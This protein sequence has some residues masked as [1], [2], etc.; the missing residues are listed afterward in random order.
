MK[1]R[2][3]IKAAAFS[4]PMLFCGR[5]FGAGNS[6]PNS[7]CNVGVIGCG[8]QAAGHLNAI[9][10]MPDAV[11]SAVCDVDDSR[12]KYWA[13]RG[14]KKYY[15]R[16]LSGMRP[17][18]FKDFRELLLDPSIDAVYVTTPDHWHALICI[19]AARAGKAV[20]CEKPMTFTIEE[21]R[22]VTDAVQRAGIAFQVGSQQRSQESF[23]HAAQL[24]RNG[25][26]G[27][28]KNVWV[29]LNYGVASSRN[30]KY[31]AVPA[32]IDWDMWCGPAPYNPYSQR[33]L[34]L[35]NPGAENPYS[36]MIC[37]EWRDHL[38]YGNS[39]QADFGAHHYD[40]AMWGLGLDGMG[41][42]RVVVSDAGDIPG[43]KNWRQ[44]FYELS[45]GVKIYKGHPG[46]G[47]C[48]EDYPVIF[49]G[50]EGVAAADRGGMEKF[51]GSKPYYK[52]LKNADGDTVY[53][54]SPENSHRDNF[55]KAVFS[56]SPTVAPVEGG[57]SSAEISIMGNIAF[58]LGRT[59]EWDWEKGEFRGD[60][61][62][63]RLRSRPSRGQWSLA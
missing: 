38:D 39:N 42:E 7:R 41:P 10:S 55:F 60:D 12:L 34:P 59:L 25:Y 51:W 49:E 14:E 23:R 47:V 53:Y 8:S 36:G 5:L 52:D 45:G 3:F 22:L 15:G 48:P 40:I 63:N 46:P 33:L 44:Y 35:L 57:R 18:T 11:L 31:E 54:K 2:S 56:G 32:G 30:W 20:Y 13:D 21:A 19:A 27:R 17:K 62:A 43:L 28:I 16:G 26:L 58:R 6:A 50:E 1:R 9:L 4:A 24:A 29:G 37:P 61:A